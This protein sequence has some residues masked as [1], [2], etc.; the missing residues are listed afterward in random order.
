MYEKQYKCRMCGEYIAKTL[1]DSEVI[2]CERLL[3]AINHRNDELCIIHHCID[4]S[5]GVA[6]LQGVKRI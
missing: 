6:E 3:N 2:A 4:G 1:P 5:M